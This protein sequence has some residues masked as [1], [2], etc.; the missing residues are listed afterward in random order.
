MDDEQR[1][2]GGLR[3]RAHDIIFGT[4]TPAGKAF[5][6]ALLWAILLSVAAVMVESVEDLNTAWATELTVLEWLFTG[7]FTLEYGARLWCVKRPLR[8]AT[9]FFGLVDLASVLPSYAALLTGGAPS[10]IVV[11]SLRLL[12]VFRVL[13]LR[14]YIS[15][16]NVL[17]KAIAATLPKITVFL[18]TILVIVTIVGS[19]MYIIEGPEYGF[20]SIPAG[21]YWAIVTLTT[22]G[23][24]DIH[25]HTPLGQSLAAM[26]MVAGYAI[27]AVPT[28]IVT[29]ELAEAARQGERNCP[30]CGEHGHDHDARYCK[31]CSGRLTPAGGPP[32]SEPPV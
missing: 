24:G 12:R 25:P 6:V 3:Q 5:D 18:G 1:V 2:D 17:S 26:V 30:D 20:T 16:A 4:E 29:V 31:Y 8:Y 19:S 23:Y 21:V 22:V 13:R 28:G 14:H 27:I 15:E 11:R 32:P 9:S 7:L 10:L